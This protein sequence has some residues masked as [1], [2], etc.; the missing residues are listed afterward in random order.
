MSQAT[1]HSKQIHKKLILYNECDNKPW[2]CGLFVDGFNT[3]TI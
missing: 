2:F 1:T 3:Q